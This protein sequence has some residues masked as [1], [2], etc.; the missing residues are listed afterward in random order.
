[1]N[2]C[3]DGTHAIT[4]KEKAKEMA[5]YNEIVQNMDAEL[6]YKVTFKAF[7]GNAEYPTEKDKFLMR[8]NLY[9]VTDKN[10]SKRKDIIKVDNTEGASIPPGLG[11]QVSY[12]ATVTTY[13]PQSGVKIDDPWV[14]KEPW[15]YDAK[16]SNCY[17]SVS[18]PR[19][20]I[21]ARNYP[22][23]YRA[24]ARTLLQQQH[25][26]FASEVKVV[27]EGDAFALLSELP[28]VSAVMSQFA[29]YWYF[30][31]AKAKTIAE[32]EQEKVNHI[33]SQMENLNKEQ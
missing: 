25:R 23:P 21:V 3:Y 11:A 28:D 30:E 8:L 24:Y 29:T 12:A 17:R 15:K 22:D 32:A 6:V 19:Q 27:G 1:M 10:L 4:I 2:Y 7:P 20:V 33:A 18:D 5:E 9:R 26:Q 14:A 13:F 16:Y 31:D